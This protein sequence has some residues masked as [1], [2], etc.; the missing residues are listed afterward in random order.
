MDDKYIF[1]A[2][3]FSFIFVSAFILLSFSEVNIPEDRF[4]SLYFNTTILEGN[5]TTLEGKYLTIIN[6]SI[7]LDSSTPYREGDTLFIDGKGY[8]IGMIT[9]NSVQLYTYTKNVKDKIYFDFSIENLEGAD[10]NYTY[11]I[12]IDKENVLE[13]NES[14]KSNEK[15]IIQKTIPFNG[16]GTHRVSILL[17]T[18]AEIHFN[19]SSVK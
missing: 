12:F 16:E 3:A 13:G 15:V 4:T 11:K 17:N 5:G 19:F 8:T 6:D 1:F 7:T 2:L 10:K 18:G 9:N 14:I